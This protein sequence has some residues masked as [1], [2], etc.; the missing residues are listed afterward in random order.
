MTK[1]E[2]LQKIAEGEG[3]FKVFTETEHQE[4]LNN[5]RDTED[6]KKAIDVRSK[7]MYGELDSN[8]LEVLGEQKPHGEKTSDFVKR[9]FQSLKHS[10][11]EIRQ[12]NAELEQAIADKTGDKAL[13][14]AKSELESM[15]RKHQTAMDE[16]KAKF[17]DLEQSGVQMR[18]LNE[19]D[20]AMTGMKFKDATIIPEDVRNAMINNAKNE[21]AKSASYVDG[22]L[23][24]LDSEGNIMRDENLN[25]LTA[26]TVLAE[27]LKS[28]IDPGRKQPGVDLKDEDGK[29]VKAITMPDSVKTNVDLGDHLLALGYKRNSAEYLELYAKYRDKVKVITT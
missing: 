15:K 16:W 14:L 18:I 11:E 13:D 7:E 17:T 9:Q 1:E 27:K 19:F 2:A 8:I 4:F 25:V 29:E 23:V 3:N 5:I 12:K 22:K 20:R 6:F 21:I 26:Q 28:I 24:F 10:A